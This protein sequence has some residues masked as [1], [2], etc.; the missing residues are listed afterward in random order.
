L[1]ISK[2][3]GNGMSELLKVIQQLKGDR[4]LSSFDEATTKQVVVLRILSVLGWDPYDADEVTPEYAVGVKKVDY[5]LRLNGSNKVFLEIKRI[6]EDLDK[7]QEQL[8]NYAFQEGIKMA[9]L[10]NGL[11]WWFYLPLH[12]GSWEQRKFYTIEI[13]D[14]V[15]ADIAK[16]F[17]DYL[18]KENISSGI[19]IEEAEKVYKG[20]Q[21]QHIVD[22]TIPK[23]W[24]KLVS[25]PSELLI[26]LISETTE[27]ICGHR[28]DD[29]VVEKFIGRNINTLSLVKPVGIKDPDPAREP[30][31][32]TTFTNRS[33]NS[34]VFKGKKYAVRSWKE[35]LMKVCQLMHV[36]HRADF[37]KILELKGRKRPYFS[38]NK[39]EIRQPEKI[40]GTDIFAETNLSAN[41]IIK[42]SRDVIAYFGYVDSDLDVEVK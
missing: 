36:T 40:E 33:A 41:S 16:R 39:N 27:K 37:N 23:A 11:T 19:A 22:E 5:S 2:L 26:D 38:R 42:M 21:K 4:R 9:V 14:Q 35:I 15:E 25:E 17:T 34:F 30:Y 31:S 3:K 18:S 8:L 12:E 7:H 6:D 32:D 10:S 1:D 29:S 24:N 28:P 20:R 13:Y